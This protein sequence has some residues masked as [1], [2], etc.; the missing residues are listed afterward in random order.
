M[1]EDLKAALE[2]LRNKGVIL[3][4]TDTVWGI[5][6]DATEPEAVEKIYSIK[7][8][9][10]KKSMIL[11]IDAVSRLDDFVEQV[12]AM[13]LNLIKVTDKPLTIIYPRGRNIASNLIPEDGSVAIRIVTDMFCRSL[14]AK[15]RKPLVSTSANFSGMSWPENFGSIDPA[16]VRAVDYV[17]KWRQDDRSKARPSSII[18]VGMNNEINIIRE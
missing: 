14:I 13:A 17:V 7:N 15:F 6:C 18:K 11:L 1:H 16:I 9:K 4:P 3:Y 2:T 8:R 5:G 10:D 12:P